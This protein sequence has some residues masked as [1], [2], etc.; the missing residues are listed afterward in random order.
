M[1]LCANGLPDDTIASI[2]AKYGIDIIDVKACGPQVAYVSVNGSYV[3]YGV[4]YHALVSGSVDILWRHT[5]L[6]LQVSVT[7]ILKN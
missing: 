5:H 6:C 7:I 2:A 1:V 4:S 3:L